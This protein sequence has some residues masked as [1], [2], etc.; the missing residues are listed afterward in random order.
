MP[1]PDFRIAALTA[2]FAGASIS[3]AAP[4][5]LVV[6]GEMEDPIAQSGFFKFPNSNV[7]GWS[8][9][10]SFVELWQEGNAGSPV[11]GTDG[12]PTGQH[13]ELTTNSGGETVTQSF[14]IPNSSDGLADFSF[15]GWHRDGTHV[16]FS[17]DGTF[18]GTIL[19]DLLD[20]TVDAGTPDH[21][22]NFT[23]N[24]LTVTPGE[25]V[26]LSFWSTGA[27]GNGDGGTHIDQ[28]SFVTIPAPPGAVALALGA[29][30]IGLPRRRRIGRH[31]G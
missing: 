26:T 2:I 23:A 8:N 15:D 17:I 27:P 9:T 16:N 25:T 31:R 22:T 11:L 19:A 13:L 30:L 3:V 12:N 14:V 18:S 7:P 20:V 29:G 5:D 10:S 6:N 28:V 24:G 1:R 21:W 4:I